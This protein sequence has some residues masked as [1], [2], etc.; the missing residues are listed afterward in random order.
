MSVSTS[1]NF[2]TNPVAFVNA[3][4]STTMGYL[5]CSTAPFGSRGS[6]KRLAKD[7]HQ[8]I[9]APR[10]EHSRKPGEVHSRIE[11]YCAG[12]RLELFARAPRMGWTVWGNETDKF[13]EAA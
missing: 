4:P 7:V 9:A 10:Q 5:M 3:V 12:P 8:V 13:A 11:R 2:G 6:P 1:P